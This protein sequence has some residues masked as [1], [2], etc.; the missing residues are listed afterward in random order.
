MG[1]RLVAIGVVDPFF[2]EIGDGTVG[3]FDDSQSRA[4]GFHEEHRGAVVTHC[5]AY[6]LAQRRRG[7][8]RRHQHDVLELVGGQ[9]VAQHG[10]F[11]LV[12]PRHAD[13]RQLQARVGGALAGAQDGGD[14]VVGRTGA[15]RH[16]NISDDE[17]VLF[18]RDTL[19]IFT[20]EDDHL[21]R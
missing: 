14:Y 21:D 3:G 13:S 10:S 12:G 9:R 11:E 16:I 4:L 18:D 1:G 20:L 5:P 8:E 17:F 6:G 2:V 15:L 19:G 7:K